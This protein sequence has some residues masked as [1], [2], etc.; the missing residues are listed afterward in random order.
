VA[1]EH[2]KVELSGRRDCRLKCNSEESCHGFQY[3]KESTFDAECKRWYV[4][5]QG[6]PGETGLSK[7]DIKASHYSNLQDGIKEA[8]PEP[9]APASPEETPG[10]APGA[11]EEAP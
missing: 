7:C 5:I 9:T 1:G 10:A 11:A 3:F 2:Y 8:S 6:Q 4:P